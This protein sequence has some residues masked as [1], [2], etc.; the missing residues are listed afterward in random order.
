MGCIMN[1]LTRIHIAYADYRYRKKLRKLFSTFGSV[2]RNVHIRLNPNISSPKSL[3][4]GNN[5]WIGD[6][7]FVKAEGG[8]EIGSGT[9]IS[10]NVEIWT[11]NHN[12]DSAD[13]M[14]I[15]YDRRMVSKQV[16]I[17]ENVWI[18]SRV[19]ILPGVTIGEGAVIGSGAVVTKDVPIGAVAGGNPATILKYRQMERYWALKEQGKVY[20]DIEYDYDRSSLRKSEYAQRARK[21]K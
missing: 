19:I 16:T 17:G 1:S 10:R 18:G 11:S 7:F 13:L 21:W 6:N 15:P 2:G 20:L 5:V 9:I 14:A 8:V 12:Y 4:I 3:H